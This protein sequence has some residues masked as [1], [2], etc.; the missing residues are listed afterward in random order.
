MPSV[1]SAQIQNQT[2]HVQSLIWA[3]AL[4]WIFYNIANSKG[5][6]RTAWMRRLIWAL[7]VRIC[8]KKHFC[9]AQP[10]C[11]IFTIQVFE[12][13][14]STDGLG[15]LKN[16]DNDKAGLHSAVGSTSYCRAR[17][18]KFEPQ[19]SLITFME[20][21]HEIICSAILPLLLIQEGHLS[22]SP[23]V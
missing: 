19:L 11:P 4:L 3:F 17:G 13:I 20:I 1:V 22:V 21:D 16:G 12:G 2:V 18:C 14:L 23:Y 5:P 7:A 8:P 15:G 9:M 6:D 10:T